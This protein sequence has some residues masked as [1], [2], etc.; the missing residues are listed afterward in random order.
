MNTERLVESNLY[1]SQK[2]YD[3][4]KGLFQKRIESIISYAKQSDEC[5]SKI[6]IDYFGQQAK[7]ECGICDVCLK[8]RNLGSL[9]QCTNEVSGRIISLLEGN[10][11]EM[12]IYHLETLAGD[13]YTF[14]LKVLRE[15]IDNGQVINN[16]ELIRIP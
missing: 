7:G 14:Y 16:G 5:R 13:E 11:G 6:L 10:G 8:K 12:K 2:R 3:E 15:M 4:R 9:K 1:I